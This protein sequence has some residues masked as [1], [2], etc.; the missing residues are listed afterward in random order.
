[1]KKSNLRKSKTDRPR[2]SQ[3]YKKNTI[4]S[5]DNHDIADKE[6]GVPANIV[7][8]LFWYKGMTV[9]IVN[10]TLRQYD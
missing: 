4:D 5:G 6:G 2:R 7:S 9:Y 8:H 3:Q 1:M 10:S